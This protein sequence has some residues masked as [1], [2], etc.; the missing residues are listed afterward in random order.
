MGRGPSRDYSEVI[1]MYSSG[2][3]SY[4]I[5]KILN[6]DRSLVCKYLQR[7]G[8]KSR[9]NVC[10]DVHKDEIIQLYNS[11]HKIEDIADRFNCDKTTIYSCL[12]RNNVKL[13]SRTPKYKKR[14]DRISEAKKRKSVENL[15][16]VELYRSGNNLSKI[17]EITGFGYARVKSALANEPKNLDCYLG[18]HN[19]RFRG[20]NDISGDIW[21]KI[22]SGA[23]KRDIGFNIT[24]EDAWGQWEKQDGVCVHSGHKLKFGKGS[25]TTASLDRID[26]RKSYSVGNIQWV[27]KQINIMQWGVPDELF[28]SLCKMVHDNHLSPDSSNIPN[29]SYINNSWFSRFKANAKYRKIDFD[30]DIISVNSLFIKQGG[31]C[32]LS[33][34]PLL[35]GKIG[36]EN[37]A[38]LDRVDSNLPYTIDNVRFSNKYLNKMKLNLTKENFI[39]I[40]SEITIYQRSLEDARIQY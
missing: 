15:K 24:I 20:L 22:R 3:S 25:E 35:V 37:T 13:N 31:R 34:M 10:I 28:V 14:L 36:E 30:L 19:K 8:V 27:H 6:C 21:S 16:V 26:S 18:I 32:Y 40:C 23:K 39:S 38:S 9:A 11:F 33:G 29:R 1:S 17:R 5:S 2:L 7:V 12:K 4:D